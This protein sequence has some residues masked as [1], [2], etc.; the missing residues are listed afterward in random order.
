MERKASTGKL[1]KKG[2]SLVEMVC[3]RQERALDPFVTVSETQEVKVQGPSSTGDMLSRGK[4]MVALAKMATSKCSAPNQF[5]LPRAANPATGRVQKGNDRLPLR[6][7]GR[8]SSC[9]Q[10]TWKPRKID[11]T[12]IVKTC[13]DPIG[14]GTYGDCFLA[15]YRGIK[16]VI[17]EMKRR[18]ESRKESKRCKKEVI[19]EAIV[20]NSLG[21]NEGLPFLL[22]SCTET[23]PYSLVIQFYGTGEESLTL[24]KAIKDKM[25]PRTST[26]ETFVRIC[27]TLEFIHTKGYLHNDLKTN[28]VLLE[29]RNDGFR[30]IIIDFGKSRPITKSVQSGQH[31]LSSADYIAPEVRNGL[32]ETTASDVYS[33][34]KMLDR[35]VYRRSFE[36]SFSRII[37][38]TTNQSHLERPSVHEIINQHKNVL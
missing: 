3:A 26:V 11:R 38:K 6:K 21:D 27:N 35:A 36:L 20:L 15:E 23:E 28:N 33:L 10:N 14:S 2:E 30:P 12:L 13:D 17:K 9:S 7:Q 25:L 24:H 4:K 32:K 5:S 16:V 22:G 8:S 31:R 34:S 18:D 19:H 1:K 37:R 29:I